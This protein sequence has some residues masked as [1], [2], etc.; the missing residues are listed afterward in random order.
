[1]LL[2]SNSLDVTAFRKKDSRVK[3][4]HLFDSHNIQLYNLFVLYWVI[5]S[6]VFTQPA[7]TILLPHMDW[8]VTRADITLA[9]DPLWDMLAALV[10]IAHVLKASAVG[11]DAH[12]GN[13]FDCFEIRLVFEVVVQVNE[14]VLLCGLLDTSIR[15]VVMP[16]PSVCAPLAKAWDMGVYYSP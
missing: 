4:H 7:A 12:C 10:A 14:I 1:M 11:N 5:A 13:Y 3:R 15:G 6:R 16:K 2:G 9:G 8:Y